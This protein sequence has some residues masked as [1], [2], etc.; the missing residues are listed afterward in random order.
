MRVSVNELKDL[1]DGLCAQLEINRR[2][3]DIPSKYTAS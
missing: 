1:A 2:F 3:V